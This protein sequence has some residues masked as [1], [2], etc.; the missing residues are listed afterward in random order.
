MTN[1]FIGSLRSKKR[2]VV[3]NILDMLLEGDECVMIAVFFKFNF[4]IR[5]LKTYF[6]MKIE[7]RLAYMHIFSVPKLLAK[8]T[9]W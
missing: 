6:Y 8:I 3:N 4:E 5:S 1:W 2:V 7:L 9:Q